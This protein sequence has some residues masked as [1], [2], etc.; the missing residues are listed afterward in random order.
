MVPHNDFAESFKE[1]IILSAVTGVPHTQTF[2]IS[3]VIRDAGISEDLLRSSRMLVINTW[4]TTNKSPLKRFPLALAD[5]RTVPRVSLRPT[6]LGK[7][8]AATPRG[9]LDMYNCQAH[10]DH[11]WYYF[12]DMTRDEVLLWKGYDSEEVPLLPT[13]HSSFVDPLT[14]EDAD[15]RKSIEVRV[16][17]LLPS[18]KAT[19]SPPSS[20]M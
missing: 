17:C 2:G 18:T 15:E 19:G 12:P 1:G 7:L 5:R 16:L 8:P 4:R 11:E 9:G 20:K 10:P 13:L 3:D 14:P 6:L